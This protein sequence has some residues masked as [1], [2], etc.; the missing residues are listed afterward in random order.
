MR[1]TVARHEPELGTSGVVAA[2][3]SRSAFEFP[4]DREG[5]IAV[6][7]T[8]AVFVALLIRLPD[9]VS[10]ADGGNWLALAQALVGLKANAASTD[11]PPGFLVV[12]LSAQL[13]LPP[14]EALRLAGAAV[15]VL[16][17]LA[18]YWLFRGLHCQPFALAG[19]V[20]SLTGFSLEMLA[21]GGYP[22]LMGTGLALGAVAALV[23]GFRMGSRSRMALAGILAG[24][25]LITHHLAALQMLI[26]LGTT[27]AVMILVAGSAWRSRLEQASITLAA[28]VL[29]AVPAVPTYISLVTRA[30]P[31]AF[32]ANGF[33][34]GQIF[35]YLTNEAPVLWVALCAFVPIAIALRIRERAWM[36]VATLFGLTAASLGLTLVTYE[37]R[38]GY[39]GEALAL[40]SA[41]IVFSRLFGRGI[42]IGTVA[43]GATACVL[44]GAVA[45]AGVQR[46]DRSVR[47]YAVLDP[48]LVQGLE[49]LAL[50]R[51]PGDLAAVTPGRGN[52]PLGWWVQGLG[53]VPSYLDY[54]PRWLYFREEKEQSQIARAILVN[55]DPQA[56]AQH[57]RQAGVT[58]LVFDT[59]GLGQTEQWLRSGRVFGD[60]G[61]VYSNPS[62]AVFRVAAAS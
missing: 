35:Q 6:C 14:L 11:Y 16:P 15:S 61:L 17:G 46:L 45:A 8:V 22:Q 39:M 52:W 13:V 18:C 32:N 53:H 60:I 4:I 25:T 62:L 10:G 43:V 55:S 2:H 37:L 20:A 41:A 51:E 5:A 48:Y 7:A 12:L 54:D 28:L 26:C 36:D 23:S 27:S 9:P 49:W 57:A 21:W 40:A 24:L 3:A 38:A 19:L 34:L 30:G 31:S 1:V 42:S 29:T 47:F 58:L 50:N 56:A 44:L 59:R 33:D